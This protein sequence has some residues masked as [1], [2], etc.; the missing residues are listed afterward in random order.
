VT[1][2]L[3]V[4]VYQDTG[5]F[6]AQNPLKKIPLVKEKFD[7]LESKLFYER[8]NRIIPSQ[9]QLDMASLMKKF[10][11]FRINSEAERHERAV[12]EV[13]K[14]EKAREK[15]REIELDK[16]RRAINFGNSWN[17]KGDENW[18]KNIKVMLER[19]RE[20]RA[21]KMK[22]TRKLEEKKFARTMHIRSD[23]IN[24]I[25]EFEK[26]HLE[27]RE[28]D[29]EASNGESINEGMP[30]ST[31]KATSEALNHREELMTMIKEREKAMHS[32]F[33]RKER[34]KRRRKMIVDQSKGQKDL[35]V[36]RKEQTLFEKLTQESR[37][38]EEIRYEFWRAKNSKELLIRNREL[39]EQS[40]LERVNRV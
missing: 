39:R 29:I 11:D 12:M 6:N 2:Q 23:V 7:A 27:E 33:Y 16:M 22:Q 25:D 3:D 5:K 37:Q 19:D 40:Y 8:L 15:K 32:E 36:K 14:Q 30:Q 26:R 34:D 4:K 18:K 13:A 1:N 31:T 24:E 38:E 35:E 21:Y 10:E 20:E 17:Q 28:T 9:D